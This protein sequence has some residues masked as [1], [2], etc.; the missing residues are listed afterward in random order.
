MQNTFK[1]D[2]I[3]HVGTRFF[4]VK[5]TKLSGVERVMTCRL[6]VTKHLKGGSNSV[7]DHEN[8][9]TV[10]EPATRGYRNVNLDTLQWVKC[11]GIKMGVAS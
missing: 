4:T 5:F 9:I 3:K 11:R 10:W 8:Y 2:L 6:G 7:L 1:R